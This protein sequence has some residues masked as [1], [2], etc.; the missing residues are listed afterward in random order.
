MSV[1]ETILFTTLV[2]AP[3]ASEAYG[4]FGDPTFSLT[5]SKILYIGPPSWNAPLDEIE[6][7]PVTV[8]DTFNNA[9]QGVKK[10]II[11]TLP[12]GTHTVVISQFIRWHLAIKKI[13]E[14]AQ[15]PLVSL[16][17]R[18]FETFDSNRVELVEEGRLAVHVAR[19][20]SELFNPSGETEF[21]RRNLANSTL[22]T[23]L[24]QDREVSLLMRVCQVKVGKNMMELNLAEDTQLRAKVFFLTSDNLILR[25]VANNPRPESALESCKQ[26]GMKVR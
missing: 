10:E 22:L 25:E 8:R 6:A 18:V 14:F 13:E 11:V 9:V 24:W 4:R 26:L 2:I 16:R 1:F 17:E 19:K 23:E 5:P 7:K 20:V 3:L 15:D 21:E 12:A